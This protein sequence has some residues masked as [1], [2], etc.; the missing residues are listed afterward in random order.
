MPRRPMNR[1]QIWMLPPS[2]DDLLGAG[3]PARFV[4]EFVDALKGE[5]WEEIG[6]DRYGDPMGAPSY[7]PRGLLGVWLYGFMSGVRS[8]RKLEAACRDQIPYLWLTGCQRPDH[9]TLWRFYRTHRDGMRKLLKRTVRTAVKMELVELAVQAVDGTKVRANAAKDRTYDAEGLRR[10]LGRLEETIDELEAQNEAGDDSS[11]SHLPETLHD[12]KV[13]R[14]QVRESMRRL[15]SEDSQKQVN[16]TDRDARMMKTRQGFAVAYNAQAMVSPVA[17][18]GE[19]A[20]MLVTAVDV[21]DEPSDRSQLGKMMGKAEETLGQRA[22][23]TLADAGY[24]SGSSLEECAQRGQ[25][26]AMPESQDRVLESPYHKDGFAYDEAEDSYRC[27]EGQLLRF[28]RIKRTRNTMMRLY[29]GSGA[30][31]RACPAFGV[32]TTDRRHGRAL[33]IGSHD[34]LLRRHRAWM[35]TEEAKRAYRRRMPLVEPVFGI[36]KEQQ[37]AHRFLLRGLRNVAAEWTLLA[38]AFNLRTLWRVRGAA[39]ATWT[40]RGVVQKASSAYREVQ[41]AI[42]GPATALLLFLSL[43]L[44][45]ARPTQRPYHQTPACF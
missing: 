32:C 26:V 21:V 28:T 23:T 40:R 30:M 36:I 41:A 15:A 12:R 13:L 39:A 42:A 16:L 34:A 29:R 45:P 38:T 4:G 9:V 20:G 7:H 44:Q 18:E 24:H 19:E 27:P 1:E 5:D 35:R 2:L 14:E 17:W 37:Q 22:E 6:V 25:S 10:L 8:S 33:E 3:H 11:V 43:R 31:C